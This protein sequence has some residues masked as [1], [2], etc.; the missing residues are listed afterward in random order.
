MEGL[1][2]HSLLLMEL[3]TIPME[4]ILEDRET[5]DFLAEKYRDRLDA[6]EMAFV[7]VRKIKDEVDLEA[8]VCGV[9]PSVENLRIWDS[10]EFL[11]ASF[12]NTENDQRHIEIIFDKVHKNIKCRGLRADLM[13]LITDYYEGRV[14]ESH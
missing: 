6:R 5:R 11:R 13:T 9:W 14:K 10:G 8:L 1:T 12:F 3:N 4:I 7:A 2:K